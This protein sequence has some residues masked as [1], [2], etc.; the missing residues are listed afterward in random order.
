MQHKAAPW[1]SR[2]RVGTKPF[3]WHR[4]GSIP[5]KI[6][7]NALLNCGIRKPTKKRRG[8]GQSDNLKHDRELWQPSHTKYSRIF[9]KVNS[10]R[11]GFSDM[12]PNMCNGFKLVTCARN[13][14]RPPLELPTQPEQDHIEE[15]SEIGPASVRSAQNQR[16]GLHRK[17]V[18]FRTARRQRNLNTRR[19]LIVWETGLLW[20]ARKCSMYSRVCG[21]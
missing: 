20:L 12:R 21:T 3:F 11:R 4:F 19:T 18:Q 1:A 13:L 8:W 5:L 16:H 14:C 9:D 15:K 2:E 17:L 6:R 10:A 7:T